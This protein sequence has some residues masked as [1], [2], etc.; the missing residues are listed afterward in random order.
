MLARALTCLLL[1]LAGIS[2]ALAKRV[3]LVMGNG[4]YLHTVALPNPANDARAMSAKLKSLGF[5]VV[6]GYDLDYQAMRRTVAEFAR[7]ARGADVALLFYAGHGMQVG[8]TNYLVPVDAKFDDETA[9]DFETISADFVLRQMSNDV[10][11]RMVF[12][13]ACRDNPLA[14]TLARSMNPSRSAGVGAG[15]AELKLQDQGGEGSVIAF[16]TSPGD[17][18][19]DG[20]GS[21]SPFTSALLRH[22]D[23]PDTPIQTVMTRVTGDVF[24]ETGQKQRP[25]VN[26]SLIGEV[27]LN[28]S[29]APAN[30]A[31]ET[32]VSQD[33]AAVASGTV[34]TSATLAWEREKALWDAASAGGTVEDYNVYLAAYPNG[35]FADFA[36]NQIKRVEAANAPASDEAVTEE[37]TADTQGDEA[38]AEGTRTQ[39]AGTASA[40]ST[41]AETEDEAAWSRLKRREVQLRL[42]LAGYDAGTPDGVFGSRSRAAIKEWQSYNE[43][44]QTGSM[45]E[46]E[47]ELLKEQ[48]Q[49]EFRAA[50]A[51]QQQRPQRQFQRPP[52]QV[53]R[54]TTADGSP[55]Y[56]AE[57]EHLPPGSAP[58]GDP[59][60]DAAG[61]AILGGAI[62]G[63]LNG[64]R[65]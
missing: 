46:E 63:I 3:A 25:W 7:E 9:L 23:A 53:Q 2:P 34:P 29:A 42:N 28:R 5:E 58:E 48:T 31:T 16:A 21:N 17:V 20:T 10:K 22:I 13:D 36:R 50:M 54:G 64:I 1:V 41:S 65:R 32:T 52:Q 51:Q 47:Y 43:Y 60:I 44:E 56:A 61:A 59:M 40:S 45:S 37:A 30:V 4:A 39:K 49:A 8:G 38:A 57:P 6:A 18:A 55:I 11:V 35:S 19:L 27:Y 33:A 24:K 15:L 62:G 14:R 26:A 12:L